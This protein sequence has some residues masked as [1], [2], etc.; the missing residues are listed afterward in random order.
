MHLKP[1]PS[2]TKAPPSS[3]A[4]R[5]SQAQASDYHWPISH[6]MS[7]WWLMISMFQESSLQ[8]PVP[9]CRAAP[10]PGQRLSLRPSPG[11]RLLL[12]Q[13]PPGDVSPRCPGGQ[14]SPGD[15]GQATITDLSDGG[16]S[17]QHQPVQSGALHQPQPPV[18]WPALGPSQSQDVSIECHDDDDSVYCAPGVPI[19]WWNLL[20]WLNSLFERS[21]RLIWLNFNLNNVALMFDQKYENTLK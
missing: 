13:G 16:Q 20:K 12:P 9:Q 1:G 19:Q 15:Q 14:W 7:P 8:S 21:G 18:P 10:H 3:I 5:G 4:A 11:P 17:S 6:Q 2:S